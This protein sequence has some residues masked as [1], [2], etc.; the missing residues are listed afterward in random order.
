MGHGGPIILFVIGESWEGG[1]ERDHARHRDL[2][3]RVLS[4]GSSRNPSVI[5]SVNLTQQRITDAGV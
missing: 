5:P 4:G 3:V 1:E 2:A